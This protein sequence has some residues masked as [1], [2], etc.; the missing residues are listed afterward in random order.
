LQQTI[1]R[2]ASNGLTKNTCSGAGHDSQE[3]ALIAQ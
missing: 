3:I 2:S 1:E